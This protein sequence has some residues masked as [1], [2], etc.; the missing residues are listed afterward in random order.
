MKR[1]P[2]RSGQPD[3]A[4]KQPTR[5][6]TKLNFYKKKASSLSV[7]SVK[8]HSK[9]SLSKSKKKNY[10]SQTNKSRF[11]GGSQLKKQLKKFPKKA[12]KS[13]LKNKKMTGYINSAIKYLKLAKIESSFF[14]KKKSKSKIQ[15]LKTKVPGAEK[16]QASYFD[17]KSLKTNKRA[18]KSLKSSKCKTQN[19]ETENHPIASNKAK[20]R[21]LTDIE[22]EQNTFGKSKDCT[23]LAA[24]A[25]CPKAFIFSTSANQKTRESRFWI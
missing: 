6:S 19:K 8:N 11:K 2:R 4:Q 20:P 5:I 25:H 16:K 13:P 22:A 10:S 18:K 15:S 7:K 17:I 21:I 23:Y 14:Y 24:E 3:P 12:K 9:N 1:E